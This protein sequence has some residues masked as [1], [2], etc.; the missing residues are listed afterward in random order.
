MGD[1]E[2]PDK[3]QETGAVAARTLRLALAS[4]WCGRS[5][6]TAAKIMATTFYGEAAMSRDFSFPALAGLALYLVLRGTIG[7]LFGLTLASRDAKVLL[8]RG[9]YYPHSRS[10][11]SIKPLIPLYTHSGAH[12]GAGNFGRSRLLGGLGECI[13]PALPRVAARQAGCLRHAPL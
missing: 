3:K 6:R 9:W 1:G 12:R 2:D 5:I 11:G 10:C 4:A 7:A 13:S 8:G